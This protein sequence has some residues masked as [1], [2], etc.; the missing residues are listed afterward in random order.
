MAGLSLSLALLAALV[1]PLLRDDP[2]V[3]D[4]DPSR[5]SAVSAGAAAEAL[6][7]LVRAVRAGDPEAAAAL[8]GP[9]DAAS[10]PLLRA[11]VA[12]A[13]ALD[14]ADFSLRYV[15]E[16]DTS[17]ADGSWSAA[18]AVTWR[19]QGF[20]Q[21][22]ART[23]IVVDFQAAGPGV[24]VTGIGGDEGRSPLW[25]TEELEVRRS[26]TT[27]V[28]VAGAP[29]RA[30]AYAQR[31]VRSVGVVRSVLPR[32]RP[33][34]VVEVPRSAAALH[35]MVG[36]PQGAYDAVAAVT[37]TVDG[38]LSPAAPTHVFVNPDVYARL[39]GRGA[40]VVMSH[41]A[42]H[43][44]T[45]AATSASLPLWLLEGFADHV[46]LR[47]VGLPLSTTAAQ[48]VERVRRDGAPAV[49]P[50]VEEFDTGATHLG[51][52]YESAWL[53]CEVVVDVAGEAAL[54]SLY[55]RVSD[56]EPL[57]R[58]L[59]QVAGLG[60]GDLTLLWQARLEELAR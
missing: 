31:A 3:A 54:V 13:E 19:F 56:G 58:V 16:T 11:V 36:A 25:L 51:A 40:Q 24:R 7:D 28:L 22:P 9:G 14:V 27:L 37:T 59:R 44:A 49:L 30:D 45:G 6:A 4:P 60:V 52:A 18:V 23:E 26:A 42:A 57:A 12:N 21:T 8:A 46:A 15:D 39:R 1:V 47:D 17:A 53:A 10:A 41:E 35:R 29:A 50:G 33:R 32:W 48:I 5:A 2:Y 34:L 55:Q 38:S 20:D 43:V